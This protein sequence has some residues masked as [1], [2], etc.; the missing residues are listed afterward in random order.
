M[1]HAANVNRYT[2]NKYSRVLSFYRRRRWVHQPPEHLE[3]ESDARAI[4][5]AERKSKEFEHAGHSP[6]SRL[7]Q[8]NAV[9]FISA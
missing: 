4:A 3:T 8:P 2:L 7:A 5:W 6:L 1:A 9:G